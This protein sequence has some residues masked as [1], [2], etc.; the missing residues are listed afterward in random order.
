MKPRLYP[1]TMQQLD[2]LKTKNGFFTKETIVA[3]GL[4]YPLKKGW[5]KK[6]VEENFLK[7]GDSGSAAFSVVPDSEMRRSTDRLGLKLAVDR[8]SRD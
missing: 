7:F 3:L 4:S 6:L 5:G 8:W 2:S 1:V